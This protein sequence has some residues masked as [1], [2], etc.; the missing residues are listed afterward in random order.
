MPPKRQEAETSLPLETGALVGVDIEYGRTLYATVTEAL[1]QAGYYRL[2]FTDDNPKRWRKRTS[3]F[4]AVHLTVIAEFPPIDPV[5]RAEIEQDRR[6]RA[7]KARAAAPKPAPGTRAGTEP[8]PAAGED[9][10]VAMVNAPEHKPAGREPKRPAKARGREPAPRV[11]PKAPPEVRTAMGELERKMGRRA[12]PRP[13][14][15][16]PGAVLIRPGTFGKT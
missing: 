15:K 8:A 3:V 10:A 12:R 11:I 4:R 1:R 2:T 7:Q 14:V 13:L 5:Y 16:A 9:P 6:E